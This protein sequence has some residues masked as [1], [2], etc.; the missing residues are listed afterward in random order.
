MLQSA[1]APKSFSWSY[2]RLKAF[3]DCP[4]RYHETQ[5]KKDWPEEPSQIL[6]FGD[7]VHKAMAESLRTGTPLPTKFKQFQQWVD[8][9]AN[10][11]GE[12]LVE[13]ECQWAVT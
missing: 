1:T 11:D 4:R 10:T 9:V 12:M 13:D 5:V 2:S 3:E 8:K 6:V 7:A